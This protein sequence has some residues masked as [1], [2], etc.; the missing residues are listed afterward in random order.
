MTIIASSSRSRKTVAMKSLFTSAMRPPSA[1]STP[2]VGGITTCV[3]PSSLAR[4]HASIGPA[5][6]NACIANS[7]WSMPSREMSL[8]TSTYMPDTAMSTMAWAVSS[9]LRPMRRATEPT[10]ARALSGS[11]EMALLS[12]SN[13]PMYPSTAKASVMVGRSP[14]RP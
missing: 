13:C 10:A 1:L 8:L 3:I 4:K 5:P 7:R 2:G 12:S 9:V 6:P 11:M 14:P